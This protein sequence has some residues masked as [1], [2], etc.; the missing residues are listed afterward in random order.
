M[1]VRLL[2]HLLSS[3][4]WYILNLKVRARI[5]SILRVEIRLLGSF[6]KG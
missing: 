4:R 1:A 6:D 5:V 2:F 3:N